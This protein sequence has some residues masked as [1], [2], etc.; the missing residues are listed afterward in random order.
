[1]SFF[2]E[3]GPPLTTWLHGLLIGNLQRVNIEY[4]KTHLHI[5]LTT[6]CQ[7][8]QINTPIDNNLSRYLNKQICV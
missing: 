5:K 2:Q 4:T 3:S 1:M 7:I 6:I 8:N